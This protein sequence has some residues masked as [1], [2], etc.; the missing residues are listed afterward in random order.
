M[1]LKLFI[2]YSFTLDQKYCSIV[3]VGCLASATGLKA[4]GFCS[5]Q[6]MVIVFIFIVLPMITQMMVI[7]FITL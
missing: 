6:M 4:L 2:I 1:S 7:V 5:V 3:L